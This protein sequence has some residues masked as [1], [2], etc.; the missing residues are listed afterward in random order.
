[1]EGYE[2]EVNR[3]D[4]EEIS[5]LTALIQTVRLQHAMKCND[6]KGE[7]IQGKS[8]LERFQKVSD[9]K[10]KALLNQKEH[11]FKEMI[12]QQQVKN[13][14]VA[15]LEAELKK[16]KTEQT[17]KSFRFTNTETPTTDETD[18]CVVSVKCKGN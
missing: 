10:Y 4:Q 17:L 7:I 5:R 2:L 3:K 8:E 15:I 16:I 18:E 13:L 14:N 6:M 1:M 11:I 9:A 12:K